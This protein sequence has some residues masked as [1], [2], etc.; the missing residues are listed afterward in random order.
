V[1]LPPEQ[2]WSW[3]V[4]L[5]KTVG[6]STSR[7]CIG[8]DAKLCGPRET[9][10]THLAPS[11]ARP[12]LSQLLFL[13]GGCIFSFGLILDLTRCN[14]LTNS[15]AIHTNVH[16]YTDVDAHQPPAQQRASCE[17]APP[18]SFQRMLWR[19]GMSLSHN[20]SDLIWRIALPICRGHEKRGTDEFTPN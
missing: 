2:I 17:F 8:S 15:P 12:S 9:P 16:A 20:A 4:A 18:F 10:R 5:A 1:F 3:K 13:K 19:Y 7:R 6:L 14:G 11:R